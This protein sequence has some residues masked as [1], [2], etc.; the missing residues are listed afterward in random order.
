MKILKSSIFP[1]HLMMTIFVFFQVA[2]PCL[3]Q[4]IDSLRLKEF[5]QKD[6]I[7]LYDIMKVRKV[8]FLALGDSE[9]CEDKS[10]KKCLIQFL[11]LKIKE[12]FY[13]PPLAEYG[14]VS[15]NV[16]V[17]FIIDGDAKIKDVKVL[18][19]SGNKLLDNGA[20]NIVRSIPQLERSAL[21]DGNPVATKHTLLVK[22]NSQYPKRITTV[23]GDTI[24]CPPI[25]ELKDMNHEYDGRDFQIEMMNHLARNFS[26]PDKTIGHPQGKVYVEFTIDSEGNIVKVKVVKS[27]GNKVLDDTAVNLVTSI[28]KI[29][30]P[31]MENGKALDVKYT[32][33]INLK[34]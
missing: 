32:V 34:L 28:S 19:S 8:D 11:N 5:S 23:R 6:S 10:D 25:W 3:A 20:L 29:E 13:Y 31:A 4:S 21:K 2:N 1:V 12:N 15:G 18:K 9:L 14:G 24:F 33:P 22:F 26:Y 30:V 27:S 16:N 7:I 17:Q